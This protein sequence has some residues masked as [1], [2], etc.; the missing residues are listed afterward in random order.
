MARLTLPLI[1]AAATPQQWAQF[2]ILH[3]QKTGPDMFRL[4]PWILDG[5]DE[6]TTAAMLAP[7]PEPTRGA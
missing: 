5:A 4:L 3:A 6:K 1:Q 2:G 7:M